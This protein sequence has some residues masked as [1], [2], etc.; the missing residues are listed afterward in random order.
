[1][2]AITLAGTIG[3]DAVLRRTQGGEPVLGFSVAVDD[4]YGE[5]KSTMW[6]DVNLWGK[7]GQSLEPHLK[8]G[9]RVTVAG[10][11]G[12]RQH[13]AKTYFTCRANDITI[14]GGGEKREPEQRDS[15]GNQPANFDDDIPFSPEWR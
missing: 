3:K 4:G 6:F 15:Y 2:K 1:M 7:R 5:N 13:E 9:T 12:S 11:F 10:E 14:Q 8:K